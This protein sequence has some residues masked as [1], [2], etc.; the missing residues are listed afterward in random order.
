ML[1]FVFR[2]CVMMHRQR[3][4]HERD[5]LRR[6]LAEARV[7]ISRAKTSLIVA[8]EDSVRQAGRIDDLKAELVQRDRKLAQVNEEFLRNQQSTNEDLQHHRVQLR[9]QTLHLAEQ[10]RQVASVRMC[11]RLDA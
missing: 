8:N 2:L 10:T 4:R 6:E 1:T 7:D 5:T 11:S 9:A 3:I